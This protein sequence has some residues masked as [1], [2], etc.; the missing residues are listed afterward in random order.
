LKKNFEIKSG[1]RC[2]SSKE[3]ELRAVGRVMRCSGNPDEY[4]EIPTYWA[5]IF[6]HLSS[7]VK[8]AVFAWTL[9]CSYL[10]GMRRRML[11]RQK[12]TDNEW[13]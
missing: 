3:S 9:K 1:Y 10:R 11:Q 2:F 6:P 12:I 7:L 5:P 4:L 13:T 8:V